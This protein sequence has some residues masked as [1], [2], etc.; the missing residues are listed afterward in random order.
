M[1]VH[2]NPNGFAVVTLYEAEGF[3]ERIHAWGDHVGDPD[4]HQH[5]ADFVSTVMEGFFN[6]EI[7]TYEDDPEGEWMRMTVDCINNDEN[8]EY[9][10]KV[11]DQARCSVEIAEVLVHRQGSTYERK[12][13]DLHRVFPVKCPVVTRVNFGPATNRVHTMIRKIEE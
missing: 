8:G 6:E 9:K 4:I 10:I 2:Q 13:T 1:R 3:S 11:L 5:R 12:A 7:W